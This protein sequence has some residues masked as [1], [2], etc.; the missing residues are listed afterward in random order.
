MDAM[1]AVLPYLS[2]A[3]QQASLQAAAQ[4]TGTVPG[5]S[6]AALSAPLSSSITITW[7]P[8]QTNFPERNLGK[9]ASYVLSHFAVAC[10]A[11]AVILNRTAVFAA[12]RRPQPLP[13]ATRVI[14]HGLV[15]GALF[16]EI[17][18]LV[19]GIIYN[20]CITITNFCMKNSHPTLFNMFGSI[21]SWVGPRRVGPADPSLL[22]WVYLS[23]CFAH[24]IET[25]C[26]SLE[27]RPITTE[28]GLTLFE[29]S[30]IFQESQLSADL[31]NE[32]LVLSLCA[33][34]SHL[35]LH[36]QAVFN[37]Y[38][39][40]LWFSTLFGGTF[41]LYFAFSIYNGTVL[42]F[43]TI[44]ILGYF[45]QLIMCC[46]VLICLVLYTLARVFSGS[47][48]ENMRNSLHSVNIEPTDDFYTCLMKFGTISLT[49]ATR[50][51]YLS[52]NSSLYLSRS[53]WLE[54]GRGGFSAIGYA[55][56]R[57]EMSTASFNA[58]P[59]RF[60]IKSRILITLNLIKGT[61]T[62]LWSILYKSI[63][64]GLSRDDHQHTRTTTVVE[65]D[66]D[67]IMNESDE[68]V[69]MERLVEIIRDKM[70][71]SRYD[72]GDVSYDELI[73]GDDLPEVDRSAAYD[74]EYDGWEDSEAESEDDDDN[75]NNNDANTNQLQLHNAE[76]AEFIADPLQ[77][78]AMN[79][80]NLAIFSSHMSR[81]DDASP[82]TRSKH[83]DRTHD[84]VKD[85][86][87]VIATKRP[88]NG[89][90]PS[91]TVCVICQSAPRQIVLWPCRCFALCEECRLTLAFKHFKG[92]VCCRRPVESFSRVYVP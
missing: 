3:S 22:W 81:P 49:S 2:F 55:N 40:R 24:F 62:L 20:N 28:T 67:D 16:F 68:N 4:A 35:A 23:I 42:R 56:E 79:V 80:D 41:L 73:R 82:M 71:Y 84:E 50:A 78:L 34:L 6:P 8:S 13:F 70:V 90:G 45:P 51:T 37:S 31:S 86:L 76:F 26:G 46:V 83:K 92:C 30:V 11:M 60:G 59:P 69:P 72:K 53:T 52:E 7:N 1:D 29:Y 32:I 17:K 39:Y 44:C 10:I 27:G 21:A 61:F 19:A 25:F 63:V 85:L 18:P 89:P 48:A 43:P 36:L 64:R 38:K 47:S 75:N 65:L 77:L 57:K 91:E 33:C 58:G 5:A 88:S 15:V 87:S 54:S 14:L 12:T 66:D 74:D 9:I